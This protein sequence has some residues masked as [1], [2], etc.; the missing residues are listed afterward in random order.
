[1]EREQ[2]SNMAVFPIV[3]KKGELG[4]IVMLERKVQDSLDLVD[5]LLYFIDVYKRQAIAWLNSSR[6]L[7]S[8]GWVSR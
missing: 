1:M 5:M 8:V 4:Y 7:A 6:A 3:C 2:V